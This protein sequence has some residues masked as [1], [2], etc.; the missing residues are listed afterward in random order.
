MLHLIADE[1]DSHED[2]IKESIRPS[3]G[4]SKRSHPALIPAHTLKV[5][6][7]TGQQGENIKCDTAFQLIFPIMNIRSC[8]TPI[9]RSCAT[10][11]HCNYNPITLMMQVMRASGDDSSEWSSSGAMA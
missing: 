7:R 2:A 3:K 9:I 11:S 1:D 8:A 4:V 6:L 10:P 5:N